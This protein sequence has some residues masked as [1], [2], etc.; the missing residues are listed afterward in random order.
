M[1]Q[2]N[3]KKTQTLLTQLQHIVGV[4]YLLTGERQTERYR[5][6]FRSGSGSALAVVFPSTLLQQ[7]Q[8]LQACVAADTIVIMQAANTGLTEG[9]TPSGDNYDRPIVILNTL[10]LNQI[11]LLN[12]G[13]QVIGFPGSTLNQLEKRLKPYDREPHSVIGSSCIGASVIGGICNNS[14]GSLVQRGPAYT[15]MALFAQIDAQ[16]EL[17]LI[18]HLGIN[19]GNTPEEILQCLE[20]GKYRASDIDQGT[21]QASDHEYATRVRD[22]D[23]PTPSRFNADPRR[24]FEASGC[25]GKLAVF[26]VR[27]DTFPSEKQQQVFYI[28]TNQTQVLT[29]LR[30]A[31][32]RDFKHLPIA[33]EYMHRDIFDI[34]EVYGKDTFV[35]INSMGTNNMPRFFTLKGKI[36]ARLSKVPFLVDHLTDRIMQGFSQV[37]P[38]HLPKRLKSYRNRYEHHLMLKMSGQG[39]TEAQQFLKEFFATAEGNFITCTADEAKKAFLHRFAA[40]GAA[41]RYHAV[42]ADKVEDILALDIALPRN[43][44]QWFETL[45]PEIDQCL[46]A[47]LYYGH[48]LCHV[49]HQDYI[50]KK[51]VDTHALKQKMLALLNDKGAEYPAEHNVGHLYIAKPALKDFYQQIDPT[52]SF[53]PG[54]GKTSKLKYWQTK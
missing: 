7:W 19:L 15:E 40:A 21:Q 2:S 29:E 37:L 34:A 53:N 14:G 18:N 6:G 28:S 50:V 31:I 4:R 25:A 35:M 8:L 30:R 36:D 5:T 23:A 1:K 26:A 16:G 27:L 48:F 39:I 49:F 42:H 9:S 44:E 33:G 43:E 10:R 54:I 11:Q 52:N 22:I 32:L 13:K 3:D 41:V 47:K 17:Q 45:P 38:N 20:R 12:D 51:G 24:L 46:V